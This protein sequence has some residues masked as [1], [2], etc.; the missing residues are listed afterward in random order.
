MDE[1]IAIAATSGTERIAS[2]SSQS[3]KSQKSFII[4][5]IEPTDQ[6][7][8]SSGSVDSESIHSH[9]PSRPSIHHTWSRNT[10]HSW[11][12]DKELTG[13]TTVTTNATSD[14]RFEIDFDENGENPQ[15]LPMA[16]KALIIFFMSFST[17][18]VVMYSTSY[19][20][21]IPGMMVRFQLFSLAISGV[22]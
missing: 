20:S 12:G 4:E 8:V 16:R 18:V 22:H 19:T 7:S 6:L 13:V 11:P 17:L 14:P 21:G 10:G 15:D 3:A 2:S 5:D 9:S 1:H